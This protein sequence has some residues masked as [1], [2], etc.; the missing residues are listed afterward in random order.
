MF[1]KAQTHILG[2]KLTQVS[3]STLSLPCLNFFTSTTN[4][5]AVSNNFYKCALTLTRVKHIRTIR[6]ISNHAMGNSSL[7]VAVT[8]CHFV[9]FTGIQVFEAPQGICR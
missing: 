7:K 5:L 2:S 1:I 3:F 9:I 6:G 4:K 8:A